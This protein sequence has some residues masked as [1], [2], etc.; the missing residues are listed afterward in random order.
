M[1]L[2]IIGMAAASLSISAIQGAN[3]QELIHLISI[4]NPSG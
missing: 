4:L 2:T 1:R 3:A